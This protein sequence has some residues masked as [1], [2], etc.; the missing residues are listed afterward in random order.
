MPLRIFVLFSLILYPLSLPAPPPAQPFSRSLLR[1]RPTNWSPRRI[2]VVYCKLSFLVDSEDRYLESMRKGRVRWDEANLDEI[3]ATKPVR[4]KITEPKTPFHSMIDDDGSLSP[5]RAFDECLDNSAH[6]EALITALNDVASSSRSSNGG[7][8]SSEDETDAMEQDDDSEVDAGRV[9]FEEH[10][11]AHYNEFRKVKELLQAGSLVDE[12]DED[13]SR[14]Q[15]NKR[16]SK[17]SSNEVN[18]SESSKT[19]SSMLNEQN[20]GTSSSM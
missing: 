13:N 4:Q 8:T 6:A 17:T 19:G 3:E 7:W 2:A 12:D 16:R 11:K 18:E 20:Y 15:N 5:R 10:R 9:S 14:P 1:L